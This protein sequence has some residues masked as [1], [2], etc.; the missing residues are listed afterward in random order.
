[1]EYQIWNVSNCY[2]LWGICGIVCGL[3]YLVVIIIIDGEQEANFVQTAEFCRYGL[4]LRG[5]QADSVPYRLLR[6]TLKKLSLRKYDPLVNQHVLF[7]EVK[8][9]S[10]KKRT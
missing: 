2:Y 6:N 10:G 3:R 5:Q 7:H 9:P 8:M 1:M 4:L